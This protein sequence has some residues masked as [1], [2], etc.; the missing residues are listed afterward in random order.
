M[1]S[2]IVFAWLCAHGLAVPQSVVRQPLFASMAEQL[3]SRQE[4][5]RCRRKPTICEF[6]ARHRGG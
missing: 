4:H 2:I 1:L 6:W 3:K 5:K